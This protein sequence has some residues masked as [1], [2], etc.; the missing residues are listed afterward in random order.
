MELKHQITALCIL[1]LC[2]KATS[3]S[4][5]S[6]LS[7]YLRS[8]NLHIIGYNIDKQPYLTYGVLSPNGSLL[9]S[10]P[11][12]VPFPSMFHDFAITENYA[13]FM[14]MPLVFD[15]KIMIQHNTLPVIFKPELPSRIGLLP[16]TARS[17]DEVGYVT[18]ISI[19]LYIHCILQQLPIQT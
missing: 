12:T 11:I 17:G 3:T 19:S 10:F 5:V 7:A 6:F 15:P 16:L 4:C 14:H 9:K 13:V 8:G 18:F 1:V 2:L